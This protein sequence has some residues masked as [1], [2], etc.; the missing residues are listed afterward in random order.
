MGL[1]LLAKYFCNLILIFFQKTDN[2]VKN[3]CF[4]TRGLFFTL[5]GVGGERGA[6]KGG[7]GGGA[8]GEGG[9]GGEVGAG[10]GVV[11]E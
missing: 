3:R 11:G 2:N 9:E 5:R 10:E 1:V 7:E 8:G 4:G 6:G